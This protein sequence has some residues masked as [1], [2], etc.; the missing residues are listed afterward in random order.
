M[1]IDGSELRKCWNCEKFTYKISL[2]FETAICS[3]ECDNQKWKEY[4]EELK[5]MNDD[6]L[7]IDI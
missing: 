3:E 6:G 7:F 5:R 4:E 1:L 2:S